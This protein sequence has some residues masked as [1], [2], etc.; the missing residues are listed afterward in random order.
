M[1]IVYEKYP[2]FP[3]DQKTQIP[4]RENIPIRILDFWEIE[5]HLTE[6]YLK[7]VELLLSH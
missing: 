3:L 6:P 4:I 7:K 5:I 2:L 1:C